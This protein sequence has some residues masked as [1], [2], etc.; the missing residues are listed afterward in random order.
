MTQHHHPEPPRSPVRSRHSNPDL[1]A[2]PPPPPPPP[3]LPRY[4]QRVRMN[5]HRR[6]QRWAPEQ[7]VAIEVRMRDTEAGAMAFRHLTYQLQLASGRRLSEAVTERAMRRFICS[8]VSAVV[9]A[10]AEQPFIGRQ[11]V[12]EDLIEVFDR[13]FRTGR[14]P[15]THDELPPMA[16]IDAGAEGSGAE[17]GEVP[18]SDR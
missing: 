3:A 13:A 1:F 17:P 14:R 15:R 16:P 11:V 12:E 7:T 4:D 2:G 18:E 9:A 6:S 10:C 8:H 5:G